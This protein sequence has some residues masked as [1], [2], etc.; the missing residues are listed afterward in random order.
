MKTGSQKDVAEYKL[1]R[2]NGEYVY[3]ESMG[4]II[5]RDGKPFAIQGIARDITERKQSEEKRLKLE[6]Q[7]QQSQKMEAIGTLAGGV[8]HEFNNALSSI[9]GHAGLLEMEYPEDEKIMDYAKAMMQSAHRMAHLTSQLL[10][11]ARG[12][13]TILKPCH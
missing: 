3:V 4:A 9:T 6:V 8:A 5:Y 12:G 1:R 13:N 11:Y 10:A 7:L 2:K